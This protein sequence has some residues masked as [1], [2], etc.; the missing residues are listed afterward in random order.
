[1]LGGMTEPD[2]AS[3]LIRQVLSSIAPAA[4]DSVVG[5]VA[6]DLMARWVIP[7]GFGQPRLPIGYFANVIQLDGR[8]GL[9]VAT[10]GIGS[11]TMVAQMLGQYDTVGVDCVAMNVN[12]LLCV[13]AMPV[14]LT[15]YLAVNRDDPA[16]VTALLR[17]LAK[18]ATAAGI[19]IA[20]GETAVLPDMFAATDGFAFDLSATAFGVVPLSRINTGRAVGD[21][22]LVIGVPGNGIHSNGLTLARRVLFETHKYRPDQQ[23]WDLTMPLG[24]ELLRPTPIY[25]PEIV[26]VLGTLMPTDIKALIHISGDGLFNLLRVAAPVG[27]RL[28]HMPPV[29]PIF[30]VIAGLAKLAPPAMYRHFNMGVGFCLVVA[31]PVADRVL[32]ILRRHGRD[33]TVLGQAVADPD[34][35]LVI[36]GMCIGQH[37]RK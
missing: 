31:P 7:D 5:R 23:F 18:G 21:G 34:R 32:T 2:S 37:S 24:Q 36:N 3:T 11:K 13:G 12:D 26:E 14:A 30:L 4:P 33:A 6:S 19:S 10:D 27:F 9:A 25:V 28:D 29:P 20:G 8:L 35:C 17:G 22:D 16:A 15:D 1:M